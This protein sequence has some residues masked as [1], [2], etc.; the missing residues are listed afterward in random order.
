[1]AKRYLSAADIAVRSLSPT[2]TAT[3]RDVRDR[4][5]YLLYMRDR[6]TLRSMADALD[7]VIDDLVDLHERMLRAKPDSCAHP[8]AR[9]DSCGYP[10]EAEIRV[11][12]SELNSGVTTQSGGAR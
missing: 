5:D 9:N 12:F 1:M 2:N 7:R 8:D 4:L 10:S 6:T 11:F 3:L